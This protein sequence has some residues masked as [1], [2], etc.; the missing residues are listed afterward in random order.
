MSQSQN[1][2]MHRSD[3]IIKKNNSMNEYKNELVGNDFKNI[4]NNNK[5]L[6]FLNKALMQKKI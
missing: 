1:E 3:K 6:K 5:Y 2:E 4:I